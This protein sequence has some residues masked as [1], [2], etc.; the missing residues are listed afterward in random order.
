MTRSA[1]Q[2]GAA[3]D[4]LV[5]AMTELLRFYRR[6][7]DATEAA[8]SQGGA[9]SRGAAPAEDPDDLASDLR[10]RLRAK[11]RR[12]A[13]RVMRGHGAGDA[14]EDDAR[15][16]DARGDDARKD[17]DST[18]REAHPSAR[19]PEA[20]LAAADWLLVAAVRRRV[21]A[22]CDAELDGDHRTVAAAT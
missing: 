22:R 8:G 5:C 11:A 6:R 14:C 21:R 16:D 7:A 4:L 1:L 20:L 19:D 3:E 15:E 2:Q 10:G 17:G 18:E 13:V 12:L 9:G